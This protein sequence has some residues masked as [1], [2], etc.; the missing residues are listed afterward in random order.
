MNVIRKSDLNFIETPGANATA[1]IATASRGAQDVS[2]IRQR[3]Q[4]AAGILRIRMT[5]KRSYW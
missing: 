4:P 5:G 3:Q 1:G 2:V